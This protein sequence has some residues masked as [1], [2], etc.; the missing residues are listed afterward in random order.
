MKEVAAF[1]CAATTRFS[2]FI[3]S[4]MKQYPLSPI[5][6]HLQQS[7]KN[8]EAYSS[9]SATAVSK[10]ETLHVQNVASGLLFAYEQLRNASENIEDHLLLQ[11]AILR[12]YKRNIALYSNRKYS[13]LAEEL[14]IEL[15]QA[16]YIQNDTISIATIDL[17]QEYV[18]GMTAFYKKARKEVDEQT[19][20]RWTLE[21]LSVKTEYIINPPM[22]TTAYVHFVHAH[23]AEVIDYSRLLDSKEEVSA[24]DYPTLLYIAIHKALL[25]SDDA[26][27]RVSLEDLYPA[28]AKSTEMQITLNKKYDVLASLDSTTNITKFVDRNGAALRVMRSAFFDADNASI[29]SSDVTS[30]NAVEHHL[31]NTINSEYVRVK[32]NVN[33]GVIKSIIFLLVTKALVGLLVEIPYDLFVYGA[34]LVLPLVIN[35]LFPSLIIA[36]SALTL[37]IPGQENT[38]AILRYVDT[39]LY[40]Q[41]KNTPIRLRYI[42]KGSGSILFNTMYVLLFTAVFYLIATQLYALGFN[43]VQGILFVLFFSTASFLGYRLTLQIK[44]LEIVSTNQGAFA[45]IRDFLYSPFIIIGKRLSYRFS[46]LNIIAQVLDVVIDLPLKTS[47]RLVRQWSVFMNNKK[48]ELL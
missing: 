1:R 43:I 39:L 38:N 17:I 45:L 32:K 9:H 42:E 22:H 40:A 5:G 12:F 36:V 18:S 16:E 13:G 11:R 41:K 15:T 46:K 37:R 4:N 35:L 21:S 19:A 24:E 14:I 33:R 26:N 23:F 27:V 31:L 2:A 29:N 10:A 48:D 47:M 8:I 7:L 30:P 6:T 44:E 20:T 3:Y 34:I 25:K 28:S